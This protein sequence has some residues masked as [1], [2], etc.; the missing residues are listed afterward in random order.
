MHALEI[1]KFVSREKKKQ[2]EF[3]QPNRGKARVLLTL[4]LEAYL[5]LGRRGVGPWP[6]LEARW[7]AG[8]NEEMGWRGQ[9]VQA[10]RVFVLASKEQ[11][12]HQAM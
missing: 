2:A 3:G 4:G 9:R 11:K 1:R 12:Q 5:W 8:S 7:Q 6:E 10:R